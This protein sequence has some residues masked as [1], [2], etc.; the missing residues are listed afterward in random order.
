MRSDDYLPIAFYNTY[1]SGYHN[2]DLS[3]FNPMEYS[4]S[5]SYLFAIEIGVP[6]ERSTRAS[7]R[8]HGQ[9][10]W[11]WNVDTHLHKGKLLY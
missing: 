8:E 7:E 9:R 1:I 11:D 6:S 4:E 10:Y 2:S 3:Q 5:E